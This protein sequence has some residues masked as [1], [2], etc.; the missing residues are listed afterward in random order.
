MVMPLNLFNLDSYAVGCLLHTI[1][2]GRQLTVFGIAIQLGCL[3]VEC[4][5]LG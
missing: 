5:Q 1:Q 4:F 3:C 2:L